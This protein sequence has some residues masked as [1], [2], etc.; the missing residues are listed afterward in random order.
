MTNASR[1]ILIIE[2][3]P[4]I[5][6]V[7]RMALKLESYRVIE[8]ENAMRGLADAKSHRPDLAIIDLGLPDLDGV[9]VITNIREWSSMPIIVLSARTQEEQK[10]RALESGADDYVT[11]PFG[12][13]ELLAR[14]NVALR[15]RLRATEER[16]P[17]IKIGQWIIDLQRRT[18]IGQTGESLHLTP[19]EFRLLEKLIAHEGMVVTHRQLLLQVWGPGSVE[20]THYLRGYIKQLREKFESDPNRPQHLLTETGVGYR[21]VCD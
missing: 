21:L 8:A 2:D 17:S 5:R 18:V 12:T 15:H 1:A 20:Q 3:D 9:E 14:I 6:E 13:R 19:I 7:L 10:V 16:Q 11:K 4:Q